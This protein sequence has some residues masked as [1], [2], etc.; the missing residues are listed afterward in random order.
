MQCVA[1]L[2]A[3]LLPAPTLAF[4]SHD[5]LYRIQRPL[6]SLLLSVSNDK[7]DATTDENYDS[8]LDDLTPPSISFTRNSILFGDNAP[9][10]RNNAPLRFWQGTK[11]VLPPIVT[12]AWD[13]E[14]KG[15]KKPVEHLYNLLFVRMPTICCLVVYTRNILMGHP[16]VIDFGDGMLEVPPIIVFGLILAILR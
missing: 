14:G 1:L 7:D 9:T 13:D 6:P 8:E 5:A 15:D 10:Q 3:F 11:S 2:L 16:L 4:R 12:G